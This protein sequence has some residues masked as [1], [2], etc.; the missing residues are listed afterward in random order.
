LLVS[1]T[2]PRE[3]KAQ[4]ARLWDRG[5]LLRALVADE[6]AFPRRLRLKTP[7]TSEV[8]DR[9]DAV[10]QWAADLFRMPGIRIVSRDARHRVHGMQRLPQEIWIDTLDDALGI[11]GK[12]HDAATMAQLVGLTRSEC[13][14]LLPCLASRPLRA[15]DLAGHWPRLIAVVRWMMQHPSPGLY[16]R[17]VDVNGV[18]SKFIE[19]HRGVLTDLLDLALPPEAKG[20]SS[21]FEARFGF[22][23][24]PLRIRFRVLDDRLAILP[25][26]RQADIAL[27]VENFARLDRPIR[28]VFVTENEINFLAFPPIAD[29][30]VVFGSGYGWDALARARWLAQCSIHYW[31][32]IDTHGFAI[33]DQ[34]R[35]YFGHVSSFLMDRETLDVHAAHWDTEPD[36]FRH[37]LLRLTPDERMLFDDLRHNRIK[38]NLRLEQE[39]IGIRWMLRCVDRVLGVST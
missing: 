25:G 18:H 36:P 33:L 20:N 24:K 28:R 15:L 8:T 6:A 31:G 32:D 21:A 10:R 26:S 4:V 34:L 14:S 12:R 23:A 1:W 37:E 30:I 16:L 13:P 35:C 5:V 29:S 9:F 2:T 11:I 17:Q 19:E 7:E 22:L 3:V 38:D 27:D 39:R